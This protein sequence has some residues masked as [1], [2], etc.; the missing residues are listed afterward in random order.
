MR[1][2]I[3]VKEKK[4]DDA[5]AHLAC[6]VLSASAVLGPAQTFSA[7]DESRGSIVGMIG[8]CKVEFK[9]ARRTWEEY[10][11]I[12]L[13]RCEDGRE[14]KGVLMSEFEKHL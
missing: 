12:R 9:C 5:C 4:I 10:M 14:R 7:D 13:F 8:L 2:F 6:A 11:Q 1:E 3:E